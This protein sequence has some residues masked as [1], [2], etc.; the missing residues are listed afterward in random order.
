MARYEITFADGYGREIDRMVLEAP[1]MAGALGVSAD[2]ISEAVRDGHQAVS[3]SVE[4]LGSYACEVDESA[5]QRELHSV[6]SELHTI[7]RPDVGRA[8][9]LAAQLRA[10]LAELDNPST[11]TED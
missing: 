11:G 7:D 3:A 8:E 1:N 5:G 4:L 2:L 6:R 9:R 10:E